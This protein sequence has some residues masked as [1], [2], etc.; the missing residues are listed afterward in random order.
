MRPT[1][2]LLLLM[3]ALT[4]GGALAQDKVSLRF[5]TWAGGDALKLLQTLA[6]DYG[7][8]NPRVIARI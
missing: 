5:T 4:S 8:R 6:T 2:R 7:K 3:A 1:P